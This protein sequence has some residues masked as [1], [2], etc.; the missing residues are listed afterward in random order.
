VTAAAALLGGPLLCY[1]VD[2]M[3]VPLQPWAMRR[4]LPLVFPLLFLLALSGW[5][6]GLGRLLGRRYGLAAFAGLAAMTAVLFARTSAGLTSDGAAADAGAQVS[7]L[8]RAIPR[9]A[10]VVIPDSDADLH[11]QVALEYRG[12]RD[13]L[14]LPLADGS[15]AGVEKAMAGLLARRL[16]EGRRVCLLLA[17]PGDLA[18]P[19]ARHF[20]VDFLL[21]QTV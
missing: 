12:G 10:L 8:A 6:T 7:A 5:Q 14:L 21:E 3:V 4:F 1:L 18:G 13:V 15:E 17:K 9:D 16:A 2:P 11:V 19:L 20:Q